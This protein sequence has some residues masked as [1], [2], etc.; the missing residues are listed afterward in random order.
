MSLVGWRCLGHLHVSMFNLVFFDQAY[1]AKT[2]NISFGDSHRHS[3]RGSSSASQ[4]RGLDF[5][6]SAGRSSSGRQSSG[7]RQRSNSSA[8]GGGG[9]QRSGS[10]HTAGQ[11][12]TSSFSG[13]VED[14]NLPALVKSAA[15]WQIGVAGGTA[16]LGDVAKKIKGILNKITLEKFEKLSGDLMLLIKE[17]IS[18]MEQLTEV[19]DLIFDKALA[20]PAF[21]VIY[22]DLCAMLNQVRIFFNL[23]DLL[24]RSSRFIFNNSATFDLFLLAAF[25]SCLQNFPSIKKIEIGEDGQPLMEN[26]APVEKDVTFKK[27]LLNKVLIRYSSKQGWLVYFSCNTKFFASLVLCQCQCEFEDSKIDIQ[28]SETRTAEEAE[29][30]RTK[31]K[32]RKRGNIKFIGELFKRSMIPERIIHVNCIQVCIEPAFVCVRF[33]VSCFA[34]MCLFPFSS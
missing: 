28:E 32:A 9:R 19:V 18:S 24:F 21:G 7:G 26:G 20:E 13:S 11:S 34:R 25:V 5:R 31:A 8:S 22:A 16:I 15:R 27:I 29:M 17:N 14:P 1:N 10:M 33:F 23:L 4:G 12:R 2:L 6:N 30:M 3:H